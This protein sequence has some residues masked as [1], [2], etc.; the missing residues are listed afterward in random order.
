MKIVLLD[1]DSGREEIFRRLLTHLDVAAATNLDA[2]WD[3]LRADAKG[4]FEIVWRDHATAKARLGAD[5]DRLAALLDR[6]AAERRDVVVT[7]A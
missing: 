7:L 2:L 3:V 5:F 4:P 6:L 1:G